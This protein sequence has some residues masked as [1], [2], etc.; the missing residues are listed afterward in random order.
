MTIS[1]FLDL[2][3]YRIVAA[4]VLVAGIWWLGPGLTWWIK[5]GEE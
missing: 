1:D 5:R 2:H 3:G 4:A